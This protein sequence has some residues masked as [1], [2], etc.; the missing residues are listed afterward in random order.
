MAKSLTGRSAKILGRFP[1]F[2]R[3]DHPGKNL[4]EAA[5]SL[6]E[7]LDESERLL[8][9]VQSAHRLTAAEEERDVLR[10]AS[11]LGLEP[12]DFAI[13]R[14][15]YDKGIYDP[16]PGDLSLEESRDFQYSDYLAE[17]K[18]WIQ[19]I[20]RIL[21][22]GCGTVAAL[23]EGAA[24]LVD[25]DPDGGPDGGAPVP[26]KATGV[27]ALE[28]PDAGLPFGGFIHR[29]AVKYRM[30]VDGAWTLQSG[31]IYLVENPIL[32]KTTG[33]VDRIED[34]WF[35][36]KRGGFYHGQVTIQ[37]T[38]T[39]DR[40]VRPMVINESLRMGVGYRD[41]LA[42]GQVLVFARDGKVYLNGVD[43]TDKAYVFSGGM[44]DTPDTKFS[45]ADGDPDPDPG[46]VTVQPVGAMDR[47]FP[48]PIV[49]PTAT[50]PVTKMHLG[51]S[52]FRFSVEEGAFDASEFGQCVFS[53]PIPLDSKMI[54]IDPPPFPDPSG[55][56]N[57]T[58]N[59]HDPFSVL[60]LLPTELKSLE[61][62]LLDGQDLRKLVRAGL[63]R[64]R[65]AGVKL[66]V[67]Y[68]EDKWILGTGVLEDAADPSG[69]GVDFDPT[70]L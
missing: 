65:S 45:P 9:G 50:L 66:V 15:L 60:V 27:V 21:L 68:F 64:F 1:S 39:G 54:P 69:T 19:R 59:E 7:D 11:L 31:F 13:L 49:T 18:D 25:A 62:D 14:K 44:L 20:A 35:K 8:L 3:M 52:Q 29:M 30:K 26:A 33:D 17:L 2:M 22:D 37:V 55:K 36:V 10:L 53:F 12:A 57:L 41:A 51:E 48:R 5:R 38:G 34:E 16:G 46:A 24:I 63:E 70:T 4:A 67:D 6:G 28:H 61:T 42:D 23:L 58:W 40:T 47:N 56:V 32:E 43:A